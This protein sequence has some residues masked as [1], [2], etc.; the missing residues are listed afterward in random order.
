LRRIFS[1]VWTRGA[2]YSSFNVQLA[3]IS[4]I[5]RTP[6][7]FT[8]LGAE[9]LATIHSLNMSFL[10]IDLTMQPSTGMLT[11]IFSG[12]WN[13]VVLIPFLSG[14]SALV[15]SL[16]SL[17]QSAT[18]GMDATNNSMKSM[19]L[20]MPIFSVMFAFSVAGG[21]GLYWFYSNIVSIGRTAWMTKLYNPKEMAE[22]AK[23]D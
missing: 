17:K 12:G 2:T 9:A 23:K 10:G 7:A 16:M 14:I 21:V 5:R 11:G 4:A 15:V 19:M 8:A 22:K 13:P 1:P 6:E 20:I 18:N 3:I